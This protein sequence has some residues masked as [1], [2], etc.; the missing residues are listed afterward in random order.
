MNTQNSFRYHGAK[1][2]FG[3]NVNYQKDSKIEIFFSES[4]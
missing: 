3:D 1:L 2:T 4:F